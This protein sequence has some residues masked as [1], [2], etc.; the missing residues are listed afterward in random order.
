MT[1]KSRALSKAQGTQGA[2]F[3]YDLLTALGAYACAGDKH[4]QRLIIRLIVL[5]TARYDWRADMLT[6]GQREIA[7]LWSVDERTVKRVMANYRDLGWLVLKRPA[8]RGRV[9][10]YG[11]GIDAI[12]SDS[13]GSWEHVGVDFVDRLSGPKLEPAS[14]KIVPFPPAEV[15]RGPWGRICEHWSRMDPATHLSW[16]APLRCEG[17]IDGR[18][19][20][21]APSGFHAVYLRTHHLGLLEHYASRE[22]S[23]FG[24]VEVRGP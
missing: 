20:L 18:L 24:G 5:I 10:C 13:R 11:L 14:D 2:A 9:A 7:V 16:I 8:A 6:T 3:K 23:G 1:L 21:L 19:F 17:V 22:I 15:Q 4:R 12:L